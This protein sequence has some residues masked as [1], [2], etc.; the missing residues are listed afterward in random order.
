MGSSPSGGTTNVARQLIGRVETHA[1]SVQL[2]ELTADVSITARHFFE[3]HGFTVEA[4]QHPVLDGMPLTNYKMK[5]K[6]L[7]S[8]VCLSGQ[9]ACH[10]QD[11]AKTVRDDLPLHLDPR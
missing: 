7:D 5:K 10:T 11:Q 8:A 1:R 4:E 9:L 6:L 2:T 3:R